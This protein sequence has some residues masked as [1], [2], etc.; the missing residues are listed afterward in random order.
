MDKKELIAKIRGRVEQC[1][2]LAHYVNDPRTTETLLQMA[3]EGEADLRRLDDE[4]VIPGGM[5]DGMP[6]P[7]MNSRPN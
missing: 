1:R 2:R 3:D 4:G 7:A 6:H 5:M